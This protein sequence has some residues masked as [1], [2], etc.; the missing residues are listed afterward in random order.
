LY[1]HTSNKPAKGG[2]SEIHETII[3]WDYASRRYWPEIVQRRVD[4]YMTQ[5]Q[6]R[7]RSIYT[8]QEGI[9]PMAMIPLSKAV[10][11][12]PVRPEGIVKDSYNHIVGLTFRSKPGAS[13]LVALPIVDDGVISISSAFSIKN[14]YLD[15][16]DFKAAPVE[17]VVNYYRKNLEPL[18]SLYPG[19]II[20]YIARQK[21]DGRIVAVQLENGIYIPVAPPKEE[22]SLSGLGL[23]VVTVEQFE[24]QIDKQLAGIKTKVEAN[25][26][27]KTVEGTTTEK[28]CGFDSELVRKST[29]V[30][31][32]ELYQQFRL[33]VSNWITSQKAGSEVRKGIEDI[34]FSEDLPEYEKR[35]R[36][37]IFLSSTLL[38]WFYPDEEKWE[39]PASFLRKDCRLIDTEEGCTG[40][41][42]WKAEGNSGKCLLHVD[43][44]TQLGDKPGERD[45][46][47]PELFVKR[48]IDELVRFPN[49]RK[50]LMK[51]GEVSKVSTIVAPIRQGDQYIIPESSP[52]WTNLL[53]L[54]WARQIPEEPKYYEEMSREADAENEEPPEGEMPAE[55]EAILGEGTPL[56]L[57]IPDVPDVTKPL[58]PFQG[59]L[60]V[61]LSQMGLADDAKKLKK[62]NLIKYVQTTSKPVGV[63]DLT[64]NNNS[65][66]DSVQFVRP[67]T[68][69]FDSVTIF[70]FLPDQIGLL[71]Q[72]E[73]ES[74]VKI[75][76]LPETLQELY[77]EAAVVQSR[78]RPVAAP[79]E[80]EK[81]VP[82]IIGQNPIMAKPKRKPLVASAPAAPLVEAEVKPS[83]VKPKNNKNRSR[84]KPR[85]APTVASESKE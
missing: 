72:E 53:R 12:A 17:D 66:E 41:C 68:G 27:E 19:Y 67:F 46:S 8:S 29:Y 13:T 52:T 22:A 11:A 5:C 7:Y 4:E 24:W 70:V 40:T 84:R 6:S 49:R 80:E 77:R 38:G 31:F 50:Q 28:S 26:W 2:E 59:I 65:E 83:N 64:G 18:F 63:I 34:I 9:N 61:T 82:L 25:S 69:S 85:V 20:K 78:R 57:S 16:E 44:T 42:Y 15:W 36:L 43:A 75:A 79:V 76:V 58:T 23:D 1:L 81:K 30:Q 51:R 45:V 73:G 56:R 60:G 74:S 62:D 55:L 39:A 47:T 37:Y 33:I 54:D 48:V 21:A 71:I 10:D 3:R 32:E 35:K 14:I